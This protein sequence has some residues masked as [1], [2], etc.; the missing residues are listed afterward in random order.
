[1]QLVNS[2]FA[3]PL[4]PPNELSLPL[5][6][7]NVPSAVPPPPPNELL[8]PLQSVNVPLAVPKPPNAANPPMQLQEVNFLMLLQQKR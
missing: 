3:V 7:V 8:P 2:P 1:M 5:Q 6:S 4:L